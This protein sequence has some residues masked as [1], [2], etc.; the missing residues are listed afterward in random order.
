MPP[1]GGRVALQFITTES[2]TPLA[3]E[4][5]WRDL[6]QHFD[7][8]GITDLR[9]KKQWAVH[10]PDVQTATIMKGVAEYVDNAVTW[11]VYKK[12]IEK[13]YIGDTDDRQWTISDLTYLCGEATHK[14]FMSLYEF[15]AFK[16]SFT[17]IYSYL[18]GQNKLLDTEALRMLFATLDSH[19][20]NTVASHL[21][22]VRQD[23]L[24]GDPYL[25]DDLLSAIEWALTGMSSNL[26]L[27]TTTTAPAF[28]PGLPNNQALIASLL[29]AAQ[30][31]QIPQAPPGNMY[32][33][34]SPQQYGAPQMH[35][36]NCNYCGIHGHYIHSCPKVE[37]DIHAGLCHRN[38][39]HLVVLPL[40]THCPKHIPG[41]MLREHIRKYHR[42]NPNQR[43]D[44]MEPDRQLNPAIDAVVPLAQGFMMEI[45]GDEFE[46]RD[47]TIEECE[48]DEEEATFQAQLEE[49][50]GIQV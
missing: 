41:Q 19:I 18:K 13:L 2:S 31:P 26:A 39:F 49:L 38:H 45:A 9:Q 6:E 43:A 22:I 34:P 14:P 15:R 50:S 28:M 24:P 32:Q 29:G 30:A 7:T 5:Y 44:Q 47:A 33:R 16:Q 12:A 27:I 1:R 48:D 10:Y 36:G 21:A 3:F 46:D 20:I 23:H 40:G 11:D 35:N 8:A 37:T 4:C 25:L 17:V 42:L